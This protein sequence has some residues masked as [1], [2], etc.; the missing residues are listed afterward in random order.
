MG[1]FDYIGGRHCFFTAA[2]NHEGATTV[3]AVS[4]L[5]RHYQCH[6]HSLNLGV[7]TSVC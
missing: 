2:G 6:G 5:E 1:K 7:L 3:V 4:S